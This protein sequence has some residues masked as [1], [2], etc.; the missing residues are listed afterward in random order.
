MVRSAKKNAITGTMGADLK[1]PIAEYESAIA[2]ELRKSN[3]RQDLESFGNH[4]VQRGRF[5]KNI[6]I[7]KPVTNNKGPRKTSMVEPSI[8]RSIVEK[9]S[10]KR[11][12]ASVSESLPGGQVKGKPDPS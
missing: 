1:R 6:K 9:N 10:L 8:T 2:A 5:H 7:A 12:M 4:P 3:S 11:S